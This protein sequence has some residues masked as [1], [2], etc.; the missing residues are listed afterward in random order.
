MKTHDWQWSVRYGAAAALA[1]C[2]LWLCGCGESGPARFHVSGQVTWQGEPVPAGMVTFSPDVRQG[3]SGPQGYA[4]IH[5]G[6]YDTRAGEGR[7]TVGGPHS[8]TVMGFDGQNPTEESPHGRRLFPPYQMEYDL[9]ESSTT[10]DLPVPASP[11]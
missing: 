5:N 8:I 3:N 9:P 6:H 7:A 4:E 2:V 11:Q 1:C 10:L